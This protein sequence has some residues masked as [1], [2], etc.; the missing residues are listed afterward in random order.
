MMDRTQKID[1]EL[2][3]LAAY[4]GSKRKALLSAWT[5]AVAADP[6]LTTASSL[7]RTQFYDHVPD[8]LDAYARRLRGW[9]AADSARAQ[10]ERK[11]DAGAHGLQRWQQGYRLR[12]VTREWGH[13]HLCIAAELDRYAAQNAGADAVTMAIARNVLIQLINEGV[14]E[15]TAQYFRLRQIEATGYVRDVQQAI[16]QLR[17]LEHTRAELWRQAAHDLRGNLGVVLNATTGLT[18]P[19]VPLETRERFAQLLQRSVSSLQL[20]LDDVMSLARLQ[21]GHEVRE[22]KE[23]DAAAMLT[24]FCDALRPVARE[25]GLYLDVDGPNA[26]IVEGDPV[27]TR[28]I[29]QNLVLNA[30]KYT[31]QGGVML[32]WGDS[33]EGDAERW[34]LSV[35]DTG[36][37]FHAGPGTPLAGALEAATEEARQVEQRAGTPTGNAPESEPTSTPDLRPVRQE[38]GEG[39]GLSIVKRLC[40]LLDAGIELESRPAEGTTFRV[41]FPRRYRAVTGA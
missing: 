3:A 38:R 12:E 2:N 39:I 24:E 13:L 27:K 31:V 20:M 4:V 35:R 32:S 9:P 15:S 18:H 23:F 30:L 7:P 29:A 16:E 1:A 40:E 33:R 21:A 17:E 19:G 6:E 8:I 41:V 25:R 5:A 34:M 26:L 37:G 28:R 14:A 36:P 10:A 22:I 11:E